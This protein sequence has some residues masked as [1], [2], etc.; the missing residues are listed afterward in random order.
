MH[1][2]DDVV[3]APGAED[4]PVPGVVADEPG[5]GEDDREEG[6]D[7]QLPPRVADQHEG[8]PAADH[9][10]HVDRHLERVVPGAPFEK[11]GF[12]HPTHQH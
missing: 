4:L 10:R 12:T 1:Q 9:Q 5:L 2:P 6:R 8:D 3:R 7:R 11:A